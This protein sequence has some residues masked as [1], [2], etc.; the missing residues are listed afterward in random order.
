M[1]FEQLQLQ[2]FR[3]LPA[4]ELKFE[5]GLNLIHG[6]NGSGKTSII[7]ALH[8]LV[9]KRSF[10][11]QRWN[12]L[13]RRDSSQALAVANVADDKEQHWRIAA[14]I[15]NSEL[16][17]K[18]GDE[19]D[20][21]RQ[22]LLKDFPS[23]LLEPRHGVDFFHE[24]EARR[25]WVDETVFHVEHSFLN[26]WSTFQRA[27][28]QRNAALSSRDATFSY[29]TDTFI[30]AAEVL[31]SVRRPVFEQ[32][33]QH[34]QHVHSAL[35]NYL[36]G[37]ISMV[38]RPGWNTEEGLSAHLERT[39]DGERRKGHTLAGPQRAD[40]ALQTEE[41]VAKDWL[42]RGQQKLVA[43]MVKLAQVALMI[44]R[45]HSPVVLWDDWQ[46]ELS[47]ETQEAA[48]ALLRRFQVQ[49]IMTSPHDSWPTSLAAPGMMF[50]VKHT[51]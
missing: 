44:E 30:T 4:V 12:Q 31:D 42:S 36:L 15:R 13:V 23:V 21:K 32:L 24:A 50:H 25:R 29:W 1:K 43:L 35:G 33:N 11:T 2:D 10:R 47:T 20:P 27:L 8:L 37:D 38:W 3:C 28:Q 19:N 40:V 49:V 41:G 6:P 48:L 9:N 46:S 5:F 34:F 22:Q 14:L 7:E 17:M 26:A 18:C 16:Q 51:D 45:G 39:A